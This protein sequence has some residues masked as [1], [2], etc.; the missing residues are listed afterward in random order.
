MLIFSFL[1]LLAAAPSGNAGDDYAA[2]AALFTLDSDPGP[3]LE[4]VKTGSLQPRCELPP[5]LPAFKLFKLGTLL[6]KRDELATVSRLAAHLATSPD[7]AVRGF[8]ARLQSDAVLAFEATRPADCLELASVLDANLKRWPKATQVVED[9][10][11]HTKQAAKLAVEQEA[12]VSGDSAAVLAAA[13]RHLDGW[14]D[15]LAKYAVNAD[16]AGVD[17]ARKKLETAND[18]AHEVMMKALAP[19]AQPG[20]GAGETLERLAREK[21]TLPGLTGPLAIVVARVLRREMTPT[22]DEWRSASAA[23]ARA[24]GQTKACRGP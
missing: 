12:A 5:D 19:H 2:A 23:L 17:A 9:E 16:H 15:A 13:N 21:Q 20:E 3:A 1:T 10:R 4:R 6:L 7:E 22:L 18:A 14:F 24:A 8:A 11:R